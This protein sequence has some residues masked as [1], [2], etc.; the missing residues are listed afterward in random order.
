MGLAFVDE[1]YV[2]YTIAK[3]EHNAPSAGRKNGMAAT[4]RLSLPETSRENRRLPHE[5][6]VFKVCCLQIA[7]FAG[8]FLS[9]MRTPYSTKYGSTPPNTVYTVLEYFSTS[10]CSTIYKYNL[11]RSN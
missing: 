6:G 11:Y 2:K 3:S 8:V 9:V 4:G 5:D 10:T 7:R 1:E